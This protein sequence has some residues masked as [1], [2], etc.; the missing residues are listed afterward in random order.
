MDNIANKLSII[1]SSRILLIIVFALIFIS[2]YLLNIAYPLFAEDWDYSFIWTPTFDSPVRISGIDDI[3]TSQ[4]NHYMFWGGRT[5]NHIIAQALL[6]ISP[7]WHDLLN[8]LIYL[9]FV[10]LIYSISNFGKKVNVAF[11]LLIAIALW[12]SLPNF[13]STTLWITYSSNYLWSTTII[14]LFI[15]PYY[16]SYINKK[17]RNNTFLPIAIFFGGIACGWTNENMAVALVSFLLIIL[18]L[19]KYEKQDIPK[20]AVWG[21]AGVTI[22]C[23]FLF[24]APGNYIRMENSL[25][26]PISQRLFIFCKN[27]YYHMLAASVIYGLLFIINIKT[28][29]RDTTRTKASLAFFIAAHIGFLVMIV[30]PEFTP[31]TL[32]G[33]VSFLIIAN[34]ILLS[35]IDILKEKKYELLLFSFVILLSIPFFVSYIDKLKYTRYLKDLWH[36]REVFVYE[37]KAKGIMDITFNDKQLFHKDFILYR[38]SDSPDAWINKVYARYYGIKSIKLPYHE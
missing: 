35:N 20:W 2:I 29:K 19:Y 21:L 7:F 3:L 4:Y 5:I 25:S 37:Q 23:L 38:I 14:L 1:F 30:P 24:L 18:F 31:R 8:S 34:G 13:T 6:M 28:G 33:P 16:N 11:L 15:Y 26:V 9:L 17:A 36:Q 12:F 27:Y 22:G 32:F 10:F